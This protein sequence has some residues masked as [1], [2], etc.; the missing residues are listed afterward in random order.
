MPLWDTEHYPS[1]TAVCNLTSLHAILEASLRNDIGMSCS[2]VGLGL[3]DR[4]PGNP[5]GA[6]SLTHLALAGAYK[7]DESSI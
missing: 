7:L 6:L 2:A 3:P 1:A 5:N 4:R